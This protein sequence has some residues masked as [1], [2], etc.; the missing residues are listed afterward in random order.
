MVDRDSVIFKKTGIRLPFFIPRARMGLG[1]DIR[2]WAF[3]YS[4][5]QTSI[6]SENSFG[7]M[8]QQEPGETIESKSSSQ[9]HAEM[10]ELLKPQQAAVKLGISVKTLHRLCRDRRIGFVKINHKER[11]FTLDQIHNYIES[12]TV[13][14]RVDNSRSVRVNSISKGGVK[15][16]SLGVS[17]AD[18]RKEMRQWQ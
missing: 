5:H 1:G 13:Q 3:A 11:G 14:P 7:H 18:L 16:K 6:A 15:K 17:R 10:S 4:A 9:E 12:C 8:N 2:P